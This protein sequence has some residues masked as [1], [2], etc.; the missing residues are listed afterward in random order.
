[1]AME[2]WQAE[3]RG[4]IRSQLLKKNGERECEEIWS[5]SVSEILE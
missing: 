1:M 3:R 2:F 5:Q 4:L